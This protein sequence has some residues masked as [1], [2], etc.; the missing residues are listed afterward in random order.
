[1]SLLSRNMQYSIEQQTE[2]MLT[3]YSAAEAIDTLH[4]CVL[5]A[6]EAQ[7]NGTEPKDAWRDELAPR[8]A[9]RARTVP[10]LE[11]ERDRMRK[12]LEN[13]EQENLRLIAELKEQKRERE[14]ADGE[15]VRLLDALD[16]T[17]RVFAS[18][19]EGDLVNWTL[20]NLETTEHDLQ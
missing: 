3:Q 7:K 6:K 11:E 14:A 5:E 15:A 10:V 17:V 2:A 13:L 18:V 1:M 16:E 20:N 4:K 8:I 19:Q 9:V 12:D